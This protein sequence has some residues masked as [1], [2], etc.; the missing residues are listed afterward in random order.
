MLKN[1]LGLRFLVWIWEAIYW[2]IAN[3]IDSMICKEHNT[4]NT[5]T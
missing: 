5:K 3:C 2:N 1:D 4:H